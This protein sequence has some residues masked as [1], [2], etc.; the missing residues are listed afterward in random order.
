[1]TVEDIMDKFL[2]N[3]QTRRFEKGEVILA[4]SEVPTCAY[5]IKSGVVKT[6]NLTTDGDEKPISFDVQGDVLSLGWT[7]FRLK[8]AQYYYEAFTDCELI[9]VPREEYAKFLRANPVI[10][11]RLFADQVKAHFDFQMRTN[12]LQQSKAADK[13]INTLHFLCLQFGRDVKPD[14]VLIELPLTQQELANF[15]GLTRETTGIELKKL[16]MLGVISYRSQKYLVHTDKLNE[17]LDEE[18]DMGLAR[19][20]TID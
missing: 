9:C 13:V 7:F 8:Y 16:Q 12:A 4:Q 5:I 11:Y 17:L 15:M 14:V 2:A 18:Y 6:Y 3:F 1:M 10:M 19:T 20:A